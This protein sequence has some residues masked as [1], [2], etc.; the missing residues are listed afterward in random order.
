MPAIERKNE[1]QSR[2]SPIVRI[3]GLSNEIH[4]PTIKAKNIN[5]PVTESHI[6]RP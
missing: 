6:A 3:G 4:I 2:V 5:E 1:Y